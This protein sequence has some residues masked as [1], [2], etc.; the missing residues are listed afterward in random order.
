MLTTSINKFSWSNLNHY[1]LILHI[2]HLLYLREVDIQNKSSKNLTFMDI[3]KFNQF[4]LE[5]M[6]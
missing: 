2:V 1:I 5:K 6:K 4:N 3:R